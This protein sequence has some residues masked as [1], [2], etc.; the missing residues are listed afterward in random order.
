MANKHPRYRLKKAYNTIAHTYKAG[1]EI[2]NIRGY[3]ILGFERLSENDMV[4]ESEWFEEIIEEDE[5]E[6]PKEEFKW[7]DELVRIFATRNMVEFAEINNVMN[8]GLPKGKKHEDF[9]ITTI[10]DFKQSQQSKPDS[11]GDDKG[12]ERMEVTKVWRASGG[13]SNLDG[14]T[15]HAYHF[16]SVAEIPSEKLPAIK[17]AIERILNDDDNKF[18]ETI[19]HHT[20][21]AIDEVTKHK[22]TQEQMDKAIH[23]AWYAAREEGEESMPWDDMRVKYQ[24]AT[25]EDYLNSLKEK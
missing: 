11:N 20:D 24:H 1:D 10:K 19:Q 14:K 23:D 4:R 17:A 8:R 16:N 5:K 15:F 6:T 9:F 2:S 12:K 7:T 22:F 3:Y 18:W 25:L 21:K 13:I